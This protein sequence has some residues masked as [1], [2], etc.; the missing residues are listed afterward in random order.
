MPKVI[1]IGRDY[2][3]PTRLF[4]VGQFQG[5]ATLR[6]KG[7]S[8]IMTDSQLAFALRDLFEKFQD[9]SHIQPIP[10]DVPD[11]PDVTR[12]KNDAS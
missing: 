7:I 3:P 5:T 11:V 12:E 8:I 6:N 10:D 1:L 9:E 4:G 2:G